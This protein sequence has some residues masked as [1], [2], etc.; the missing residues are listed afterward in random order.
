MTSIYLTLR[1]EIHKKEARFDLPYD[2][3][4]WTNLRPEFDVFETAEGDELEG[5]AIC[6]LEE[7]REELRTYRIYEICAL[8]DQALLRL[9]RRIVRR[10]KRMRA[11]AVEFGVFGEIPSP[12]V[13]QRVGFSDLES[14]LVA[15]ALTNPGAL[16]GAHLKDGVTGPVMSF[17]V[18]TFDELKLF[19]GEDG[20]GPAEERRQPDFSVELDGKTLVNILVGKT[21]P[22][23]EILLGRVKVSGLRYVATA[24]K[25]LS[26]LAQE[27]W[28]IPRGD[29]A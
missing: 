3:W 6:T 20:F 27:R 16:L 15:M 12:R 14:G 4:A 10:A 1:N 25:A 19:I 8:T 5:Y 24:A 13:F 21:S 28:Y 29:W 18:R 22:W 7:K 9:L 17:V 26:W 23:K 11:D 2:L